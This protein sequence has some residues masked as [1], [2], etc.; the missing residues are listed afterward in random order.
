M[1]KIRFFFVALRPNA[2]YGLLI[3][4]ASRSQNKNPEGKLV[5]YQEI[6]IKQTDILKQSLH[7]ENYS[8]IDYEEICRL[9]WNPELHYLLLK[10]SLLV[11]VLRRINLLHMHTL[12]FPHPL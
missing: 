2:G 12:Y 8:H 9:V 1:I 7:L 11:P 3:R 6:I 5:K 4:E 10:K